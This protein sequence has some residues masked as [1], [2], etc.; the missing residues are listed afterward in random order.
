MWKD[1]VRTEWSSQTPN[2]KTTFLTSNGKEIKTS[3]ERVVYIHPI[4]AEAVQ[5]GKV[6]HPKSGTITELYSKKLMT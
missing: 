4:R 6:M 2:G 1:Q 3:D 5:R